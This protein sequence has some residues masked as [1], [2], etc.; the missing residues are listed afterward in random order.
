V[1]SRVVSFLIAVDIA[2]LHVAL[3]VWGYTTW[4]QGVEDAIHLVRFVGGL[5]TLLLTPGFIIA[6]AI[7]M[8]R[9]GPKGPYFFIE[10]A[11]YLSTM[12]Y[13]L[14][15]LAC[16]GLSVLLANRNYVVSALLSQAAPLT[17]LPVVLAVLF[18]AARKTRPRH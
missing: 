18:C 15:Y 9:A 13:S 4:V 16:T 11:F 7:G 3:V 10:Q 5:A 12:A 2:G 17:I 1:S 8:A 14:M 6:G